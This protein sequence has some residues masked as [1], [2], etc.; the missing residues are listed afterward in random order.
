VNRKDLAKIY[1]SFS[2]EQVQ[3]NSYPHNFFFA[4]LIL[5]SHACLSLPSV[6]FSNQTFVLISCSFQVCYM[7]NP[8]GIRIPNYAVCFPFHFDKSRDN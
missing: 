2:H 8:S 3:T 4:I 7:S 6:R 1:N 5:S